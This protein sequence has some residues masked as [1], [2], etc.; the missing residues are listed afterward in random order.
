VKKPATGD[1]DVPR[2]KAK[3]PFRTYARVGDSVKVKDVQMLKVLCPYC[4]IGMAMV[5]VVKRN[6]AETVDKQPRQ[7]G[8]C[9]RYFELQITMHVTGVRLETV[10]RNKAVREALQNLVEG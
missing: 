5:D 9:K 4:V 1:V 6:G 7:C 3:E 2:G 8:M 10:D